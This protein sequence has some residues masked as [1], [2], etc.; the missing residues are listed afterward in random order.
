M[1]SRTSFSVGGKRWRLIE[2]QLE[3]HLNTKLNIC[4]STIRN[5]VHY[6]VPEIHQH[7]SIFRYR[8][9]PSHTTTPAA[10]RPVWIICRIMEY[11]DPMRGHQVV[12]LDE[13]WTLDRFVAPE[14]R[15]KAVRNLDLR[16]S[17]DFV[18]LAALKTPHVFFPDPIFIRSYLSILPFILLF[19][20]SYQPF[21]LP[22]F[23]LLP[24]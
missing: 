3:P 2:Q 13:T 18:C 15:T 10:P 8:T 12:R 14:L 5:P 9:L 16:F 7:D 21:H 23:L 20:S 17:Y 1:L 24:F 4:I 11:E 19:P 22:P 6:T